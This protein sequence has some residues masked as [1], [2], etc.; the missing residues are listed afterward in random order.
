MADA[1]ISGEDVGVLCDGEGRGAAVGDLE[2]TPPL[3]EVTAVLLVLGA[4]LRQAVQTWGGTSCRSLG[5]AKTF[6]NEI[7]QAHM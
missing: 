5:L 1:G 4:A 3:G 6:C 2:D 7:L